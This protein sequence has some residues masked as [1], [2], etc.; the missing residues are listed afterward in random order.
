M[1]NKPGNNPKMPGFIRRPVQIPDQLRINR[2][3]FALHI[4]L[5]WASGADN[6]DMYADKSMALEP[7]IRLFDAWREQR[8]VVLHSLQVGSDAS[9]LTP[10]VNNVE[11]SIIQR[12]ARLL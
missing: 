4:G 7:I 5:V 9:Q 11:W 1:W 2:Q 6:K 8:L 12:S 10:G 3:P